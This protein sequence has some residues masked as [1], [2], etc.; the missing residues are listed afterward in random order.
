MAVDG[1]T[2]W[3][4]KNPIYVPLPVVTVRCE[5]GISNNSQFKR[6][7]WKVGNLLPSLSSPHGKTS[8][9]EL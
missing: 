5:Q 6:I 1:N 8:G 9:A 3:N 2:S 7:I 4:E